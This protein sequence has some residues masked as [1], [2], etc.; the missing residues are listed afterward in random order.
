V[1][2]DWPRLILSIFGSVSYR[3]SFGETVLLRATA[4]V[5]DLQYVFRHAATIFSR[6][7]PRTRYRT[8]HSLV[9]DDDTVTRPIRRALRSLLLLLIPGL[10]AGVD[11]QQSTTLVATGSSLPEPLYVAWGDAYHKSNP[12]VQVRYLPQG[13]GESGQNILAGVGDMGG[14]DAPIPEKHLKDAATPILQLPSVLIGIVIIYN[15]PD[16]PGELRLS[17]PVLADI[18]LGK[19][20]AWN[21]PAIVKLNPDL[22]LTAR[23]IQVIHR[24]EGKGSNYIL[25]D[26]LCKVS[27]EFLA[28]AGRGESPKF[29]V[30]TSAGRS[31]DMADHLRATPGAIGYTELNL[32]EAA[33][34]RVARVKNAAGEFVKPTAKSIAAAA[35]AVKT[36]D[37]FGVSLTN[38]AGKESYPISSFTWF[39]VPAKAK[40]PERGRAVAEYLRWIYGDGQTIAQDQGY[41][42]LPKELLTKVAASAASIH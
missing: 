5:P 20:K 41:A 40:D 32:A 1:R 4:R 7:H 13:T 15:L 16:T 23:A 14:G 9:K 8:E 22:K 21:D 33:S 27:P 18:F 39:Y 17:G 6:F 2:T 42:T 31:Q 12:S 36:T 30:G 11:G 35:L 26:F 37:S 3:I 10:I 29:P 25:S 34:L 38:A 24:T 28:K 19:I